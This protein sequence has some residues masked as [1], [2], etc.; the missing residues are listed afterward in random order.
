[1]CLVW[2]GAKRHEGF[3]VSEGEW[4]SRE[5]LLQDCPVLVEEFD[6]VYPL[7]ENKVKRANRLRTSSR[8]SA[9]L[10]SAAGAGP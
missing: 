3:G 4:M 1:M 8:V 5:V 7:P 6:S 9:R 2:L 10:A